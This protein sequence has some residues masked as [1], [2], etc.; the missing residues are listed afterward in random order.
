MPTYCYRHGN[1]VE[2]RFYEAG[3]QPERLFIGGKK[4]FRSFLDENCSVPSSK[5]WPMVD[6]AAGVHANDAG[7]LREFFDQK[8]VP[9]EVTSDGDPVYTSAAHRRKCLKC[10]GIHDRNSF[11]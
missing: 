5:G 7:K 6:Y 10:R 11:I 1:K 9:T 4:Y 3:K 2:T 8:G